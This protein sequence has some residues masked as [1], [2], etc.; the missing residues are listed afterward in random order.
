MQR[1]RFITFEGG[2]GTGKSTQ[3]RILTERLAAGGTPTLLTREPGG[4]EGAEALRGLLLQG[5][6]SRWSPLSETLLM[7][8]AR[9]DHLEKTIRP[10]LEAGTWVVS[11]RFADSTRAYQGAGG[12]VPP[13]FIGELESAVVAHTRPDLTVT[14]DVPVE[15]GLARAYGRGAYGQGAYGGGETD[16]FESKDLQ[17]HT[18]LAAAF[19]DIARHD[20]DRCVIIDASGSP[21]A[22]AEAVWAAV[23]ERLAVAV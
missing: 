12:G 4:S 22:V 1:G 2:E 18:R 21:E 15:V 14:F 11:D 3:A 10:A 6:A 13:E 23:R 8:A 9:A 7:Y 5:E 16:R 20:P 19:L 17:F